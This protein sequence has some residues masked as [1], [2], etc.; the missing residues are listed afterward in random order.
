MA[1]D[2]SNKRRAVMRARTARR[3]VVFPD[4]SFSMFD[5]YAIGDLYLT[6]ESDPGVGIGSETAGSMRMGAGRFQH[7]G[8]AGGRF[9]DAGVGSGRFVQPGVGAGRWHA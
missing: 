9:A 2:T 4:G 8:V 7:A 1:I 5:L 3:D 6:S